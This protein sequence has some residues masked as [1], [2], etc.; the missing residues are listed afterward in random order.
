MQKKQIFSI[1]SVLTVIFLIAC[2]SLWWFVEY[3][4]VSLDKQ[5]HYAKRDMIKLKSKSSTCYSNY[6]CKMV[7][8]PTQECIP[9]DWIISYSKK[10]D[11][12]A[13][14]SSLISK[15]KKIY[16]RRYGNDVNKKCARA[17]K[18]KSRCLKGQCVVKIYQGQV[19]KY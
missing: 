2:A 18:P 8:L 15:Y 10:D 9:V 5:L 6:D 1:A 14:M 16:K 12:V 19:L 17:N 13:K 4:P 11:D 7:I 3:H